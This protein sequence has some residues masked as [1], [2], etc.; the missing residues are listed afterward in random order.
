M[1]AADVAAVRSREGAQGAREVLLIRRANEPF[2][3]LWALPGGFVEMD[4]DIPDAASREL[5]EETGLEI[6]PEEFVEVG[7][8][9]RP[10]RDPRGRTISV[11]YASVVET[12]NSNATAGDDAAEA[13][14]FDIHSLPEL[15]FDHAEVIPLAL[16][17]LDAA[18]R[19]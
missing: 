18:G 7:V 10:G 16:T 12:E 14:W 9:G 4:E 3:G 1:V 13:E 15:A 2:R 6:P 19:R 8:F 17:R 5:R 11:V